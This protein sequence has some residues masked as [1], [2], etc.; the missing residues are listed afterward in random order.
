MKKQL[1]LGLTLL[2]MVAIALGTYF[3]VDHYQNQKD[4]EESEKSAALQL[5]T[6]NSNDIIKLD[7]HTP[8]LDYT[9]EPNDSAEWEAINAA[10]IR[11]TFP[12]QRCNRT[13]T[14]RSAPRSWHPPP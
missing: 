8:E 13:R 2:L 4:A 6:F 12:S 11:I 1:I 14:V 5:T 7:L 10:D 9:V 3:F